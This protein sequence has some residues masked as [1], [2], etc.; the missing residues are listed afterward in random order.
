MIPHTNGMS[1]AICPECKFE[2]WYDTESMQRLYLSGHKDWPNRFIPTKIECGGCR[3]TTILINDQRFY[4]I[5]PV[6]PGIEREAL[7]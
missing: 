3:S 1:K 2:N 7:A 6:A 4:R 5:E